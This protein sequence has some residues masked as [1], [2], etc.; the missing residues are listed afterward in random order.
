MA[1]FRPRALAEL[2]VKSW[3]AEKNANT[4][5]NVFAVYKVFAEQYHFPPVTALRVAQSEVAAV[6][7]LR[8]LPENLS[9]SDQALPALRE[10][11]VLVRGQ[12]G[13]EMDPD[14]CARGEL[15]WR[16]LE[17]EG[18]SVKQVGESMAS[19]MAQVYGGS[20]ADYRQAAVA[21]AGARSFVVGD[22]APPDGTEPRQAAIQIAEEA[23]SKLKEIRSN[24]ALAN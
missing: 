15:L 10:K 8:S 17:A 6:N 18:G 24:S 22:K 20:A 5:A 16:T 4:L 14:A 21:L 1:E 23:Y 7:K 3:V 2:R 9:A 13:R 19:L 12:L 11:Y